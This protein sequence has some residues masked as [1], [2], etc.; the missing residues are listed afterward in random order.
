MPSL[1]DILQ[2]L[3]A[4]AQPRQDLGGGRPYTFAG[5]VGDANQPTSVAEML[6]RP[7]QESPDAEGMGGLALA[8]GIP[9]G[10]KMRLPPGT[11]L[12]K[13]Y[14]SMYERAKSLDPLLNRDR[15]IQS[16]LNYLAMA[17]DPNWHT[18]NTTVRPS[19]LLQPDRY[20]PTGPASRLTQVAAVLDNA[21]RH[22]MLDSKNLTNATLRQAHTLVSKV[23]QSI[24]DQLSN[25]LE[26]IRPERK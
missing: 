1:I 23:D 7:P 13:V 26:Q 15:W 11:D 18:P 17:A 9:L 24:L 19:E 5:R 14:E 12:G 21:E 6:M 22:G 10:S 4:Q 25:Y 2:Q 3:Q 16:R 20:S 8:A